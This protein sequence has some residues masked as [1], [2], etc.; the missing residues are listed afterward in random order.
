MGRDL[1]KSVVLSHIRFLEESA[2]A[3]TRTFTVGAE[4]PNPTGALRTVRVDLSITLN[5]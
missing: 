1:V 2:E 4:V 3:T 5:D